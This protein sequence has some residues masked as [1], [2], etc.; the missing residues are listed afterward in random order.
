MPTSSTRPRQRLS[1]EQRREQIVSA[2]VSVLAEHGFRGTSVDAI[3][4]RAGVSKGL[5]WHYFEDRDDLM[6]RTAEHALLELRHAVAA[7][8]DLTAPAPDVIRAAIH[9]AAHTR[10]THG[11]QRRALDEIVNN[12]RTAEGSARFTLR[13]YE[14]MYL[15]QE[16]IFRRGQDDGDFRA[17]LNPRALAV[18][19][20]GAVDAML[21]YLDAH[22]DVDA[23]GYAATV[24]DI[25][26]DGIVRSR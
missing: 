3:A 15:A 14:D 16:R 4:Q 21:G 9:G 18:T 2:T 26:L 17:A 10:D 25:L 13:D 1:A 23:D 11:A 22:P 8:I 20:Q 5:M 24:A 7:R 19:Y 6:V 12:L